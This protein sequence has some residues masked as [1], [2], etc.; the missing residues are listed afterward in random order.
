MT[1]NIFRWPIPHV[2]CWFILNCP[3]LFCYFSIIHSWNFLWF[4]LMFHVSCL[5]V[6][7]YTDAI[8]RTTAVDVREKF[9]E[10]RYRNSLPTVG[11]MRT[12]HSLKSK[13]AVLTQ[14]TGV[15]KR[16]CSLNMKDRNLVSLPSNMD[17][18]V[19]KS[20]MFF[21]CIDVWSCR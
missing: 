5:S 13:L 14:N 10:N 8:E 11:V 7:Y 16:C 3:N 15:R 4:F 21:V 18:L 12:A 6:N 9:K 19:W 17:F 2:L 20:R 1:I